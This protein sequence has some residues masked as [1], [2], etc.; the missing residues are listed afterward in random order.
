MTATGVPVTSTARRSRPGRDRGRHRHGPRHQARAAI[1]KTA[2]PTAVLA[3]RDVTYTFVVTNTGDAALSNSCPADDKCAPLTFTGG[4]DNDNGLL[5]GTDSGSPESWTYTCT[6]AGRPATG[7]GHRRHQHRGGHRR[8]PARQRLRATRHRRGHR[9]RTRRSTWRSR[10]A[11][12][13]PG[14]HE[15]TYTFLATNVGTSPVAGR[16]RPG[17]PPFATSASRPTRPAASRCWSPRRAATRTTSSTGRPRRP[18]ATPARPRSPSPPSI[19]RRWALWAD[20]PS[21]ARIPVVDFA[22]AQVTPFHPGID[23]EKS[24]DPTQLNGS[25]DGHLHLRGPQHRR[26]AA[27]RGGGRIRDDTCSPVHYV[28]G[29]QD[30]DGLLDTPTSIFEDARTRPGCSPAPPRS[31][32]TPPTP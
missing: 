16:R 6:R 5:D 23:V 31:T 15:V 20:R 9:A 30:D 14:G 4:D 3:G 27:G 25:G 18:G 26:R 8:R 21:N 22:T 10:S 11:R 28:S 7:P 17:P 19:S 1:T 12:P 24:A 2:S 32:R 13:G 29:D